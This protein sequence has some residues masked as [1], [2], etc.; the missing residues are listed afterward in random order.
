MC[1]IA[2]FLGSPA[3]SAPHETLTAMT[4]T[5]AHRGPDASGAWCDVEQSIGLGH[6]RLSV[7]DLSPS[8][9]QPM[10]SNSG[11]Y[12]IA[13]NGEAYNFSA[14][15]AELAESGYHF[16][17]SSD[18]EVF[19]AAFER[20][21]IR[22]SIP[23]FSGMF[24][25]AVWDRESHELWLIR[26]RLGEKPLYYGLVASAWVFGSELKCLK[27]FP[28]W[29]ATVNIRAV[30]QFLRHG[31]IQSP[32]SIYTGVAKVRPG[33]MVRLR[34]GSPPEEFQY[35]SAETAAREGMAAPITGGAEE[36]DSALEA[37]LM[38]VVRDEMV[39]D[40]PLGAFLS[41]G[42]DSSLIVALMQEQTTRRVRTFTIGFADARYDEA[43]FASTVAKH[44][45][46]DHTELTVSGSD[47]LNLVDRLTDV[48]DEP[49][50]D[51]S[52]LPTLLVSQL[53]RRHVTVA[54]SGDGGDEIFGGYS[55]HRRRGM[56][57]RVAQA[58][59]HMLRTPV[60][61]A[62]GAAGNPGN[63]TMMAVVAKLSRNN[64]SRTALS[65]SR[66]SGMLLG[67]GEQDLFSAAQA[68]DPNAVRLLNPA[69]QRDAGTG[70]LRGPW[71][72]DDA[73]L[74]SRMLLDAVTYLPDDLLVKV[75]R[76]SMAFA[77]ETR[78]P[79]LDHRVFELAW[80]IPHSEKVSL[81][82]GKRPLRRLLYKRVP[83]HLID[84]PKRG[85]SIP[86]ADWLRGPLHAW[87]ADHLTQQ[88]LRDT[89]ILNE[90]RVRHLWAQHQSGVADHADV[91]WAITSLQCF[92]RSA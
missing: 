5:I 80:R 41:G 74:E 36:I 6:R 83:Q 17:G 23:R 47:A 15:R 11:R 49:L 43:K 57:E 84:R 21:G 78:A 65:L 53:T 55:W 33:T 59:P 30:T 1:G 3:S 82:E 92:L 54:L 91:L 19:L 24:A 52:Q 58:M 86:L 32:D 10:A 9:A 61:L 64:S 34:M 62:L 88:A 25:I 75:D 48:Y 45:D 77:L 37:T 16:R 39:A 69:L 7:I 22:S 87:V 31:Y 70:A 29:R 68:L 4:D 18:T 28:G 79:L 40:V 71:L 35:W 50:A 72:G 12:L 26:D 44:L 60:G 90:E 76:A 73:A 81:T 20:W 63:D 2:G 13:F 51:S 89:G 42:V 27:A 85:F 67:H 56:L 14:I 46:T 38:E 8:G 66:L